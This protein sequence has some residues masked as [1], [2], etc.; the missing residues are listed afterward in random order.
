MTAFLTRNASL[1][2]T[3]GSELR[4]Q[5]PIDFRASRV[6][7]PGAAPSDNVKYKSSGLYVVR[8]TANDLSEAARDANIRSGSVGVPLRVACWITL[9]FHLWAARNP[10]ARIDGK[11]A[12]F[13]NYCYTTISNQPRRSPP[14]Y[15]RYTIFSL[16][17]SW[18]VHPRPASVRTAARTGSTPPSLREIGAGI[19]AN[20]V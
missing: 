1:N 7:I 4:C 8:V 3:D 10:F 20:R 13:L 5:R 12:K 15:R 19:G 18:N 17:N 11:T 9:E 2:A 14:S 6:R 16:G